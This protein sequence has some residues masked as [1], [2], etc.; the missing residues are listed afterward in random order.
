VEFSIYGK[1]KYDFPKTSTP[2]S[3]ERVNHMLLSS[4]EI[5]YQIKRREN[6]LDSPGVPNVITRVPEGET[7]K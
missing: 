1:R 2:E 3:A 7:R 6:I 5:K 4:R